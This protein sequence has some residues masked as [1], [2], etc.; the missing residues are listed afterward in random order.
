MPGVFGA[1]SGSNFCTWGYSSS[2]VHHTNTAQPPQQT[3]TMGNYTTCESAVT[4]QTSAQATFCD[5]VTSG[6]Q[7][8]YDCCVNM[9]VKLCQM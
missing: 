1:N 9:L 6:M 2:P 4:L 3:H 8:I 7:V 5:V